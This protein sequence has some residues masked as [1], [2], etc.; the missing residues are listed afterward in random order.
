MAGEPVI[1]VALDGTGYGDDGAI[2]GGEFLIA[3]YLG[4]QRAA[5][6]AY[7]PLPGGDRAVRE[8]W[9]MAVGWLHTSGLAW[10]EDLPP[11]QYARQHS[12]Q[13]VDALGV[14]QH[15][16]QSGLNAPQTSSM[17]RLFDAASALMG[18]RQVVN[19]EAQAAIELEAMVAGRETSY[20]EMRLEDWTD[21]SNGNV[22]SNHSGLALRG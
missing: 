15:Q 18:V 2:W 21:R 4:Y 12:E 9:R 13:G 17:G 14:L 7:S 10:D 5:H 8:P 20:Y 3:D 19:Y 6:L 22:L 16:I 1:G 11:V